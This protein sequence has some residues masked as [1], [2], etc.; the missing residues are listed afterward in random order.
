[1]LETSDT[2]KPS[3]ANS[4]KTPCGL[5]KLCHDNTII[6]TSSSPMCSDDYYLIFFLIVDAQFDFKDLGLG[7]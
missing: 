6:A 4:R 3:I 7:S 5:F 1:M 2:T